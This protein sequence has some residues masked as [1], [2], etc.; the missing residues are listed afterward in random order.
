MA[1][2]RRVRVAAGKRQDAKVAAH[3]GIASG[4]LRVAWAALEALPSSVSTRAGRALRYFWTN[5]TL[6]PNRTSNEREDQIAGAGAKV[7]S[8][9]VTAANMSPEAGQ[10]LVWQ[11]ETLFRGDL[12]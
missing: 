5:R 1:G 2:S 4:A 10:R 12:R 6:L 7:E 9:P 8:V 3:A 11:K